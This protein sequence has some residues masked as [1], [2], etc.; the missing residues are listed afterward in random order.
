MPTRK[1]H[2]EDFRPNHRVTV[3]N[4]THGWER[5]VY[6]IYRD[7]AWV[8]EFELARYPNQLEMKFVLDEMF[9][10]NGFNSTSN[11]VQFP[12]APSRLLHGYD[13]LRTEEHVQQQERIR[14]NLQT[15]IDYDV[16]SSGFSVGVLAD[17]LSD[18][19]RSCCARSGQPDLPHRILPTGRRLRPLTRSDTSS[20]SRL[21]LPVRR[22][23][24]PGRPVGVLV[25][26]ET[27]LRKC[28]TLGPFQNTTVAKLRSQ[29][30]STSSRTCLNPCTSRTS[31]TTTSSTMYWRNRRVSSRP[32][33]S[34]STRWPI[35]GSPRQGGR[36]RRGIAGE[37]TNR[38]RSSLPDPNGKIGRGLTDHPAF[39]SRG[40][41]AAASQRVRRDRRPRQDLVTHKQAS[42]SQHGYNVEVLINPKSTGTS[43]TPTT[44]SANSE[45]IPSRTRVCGLSCSR[46]PPRRR[47]LHPGSR[48]WRE[49]VG[50]GEAKPV[51]LG[52]VQ[53]GPR[54]AQRHHELLACGTVRSVRGHALRR[55][56][57]PAPRW[58]AVGRAPS[59]SAPSGRVGEVGSVAS[60]SR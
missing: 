33:I 28:R 19:G 53:R 7:G 21:K 58:H 17:A 10:M 60:P 3:R 57:D 43:G 42:L 4:A 56:R 34:C 38:V 44:S 39:F 20:T 55:R 18:K 6:G 26:A 49:G 1:I 23:D 45:S 54:L 29:F 48:P 22:A 11:L 31:A 59:G 50:E 12:G 30:P 5:D 47:P 35:P 40:V 14:S 37:P 15:G 36:T 16:S 13:N 9:W 2:P 51:R 27:L 52:A 41:L 25:A 24:E 32:P 46:E 8:F